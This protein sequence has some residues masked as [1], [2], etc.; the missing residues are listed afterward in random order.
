MESKQATGKS[1][2]VEDSK[3]SEMNFRGELQ[4]VLPRGRQYKIE[5]TFEASLSQKVEVQ[6]E[7][8]S[9]FDTMEWEYNPD[10]HDPEGNEWTRGGN[11]GDN[12]HRHYPNVLCRIMI[13]HKDDND[14]WQDSEMRQSPTEVIEEGGRRHAQIRVESED[15][16]DNDWNDSIVSIKWEI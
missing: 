11:C 8:G 7:N 16:N 5:P 15:G 10:V 3:F 14:T 2:R 13:Q 9:F 4:L 1:N 12:E 6:I